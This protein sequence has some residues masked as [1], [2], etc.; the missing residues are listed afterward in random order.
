MENAGFRVVASI[1]NDPHA[2]CTYQTNFSSNKQVLQRDLKTF[3][4]EEL[5]GLI[6]SKT[7]V[8]VIVGG[9][10]CQGFSTARKVDGSNH[11]T[12]II[13]DDRRYLFKYFL[14][15]VEYFRPKIFIMENVRGIKTAGR[16]QIF[17]KI[18]NSGKRIGYQMDEAF[19][20]AWQFGIPQKRIRQVFVGVQNDL[21]AFHIGDWFKPTHADLDRGNRDNL[22]DPVTLWEAIGDLPPLKPGE[23]KTRYNDSKR[24]SQIKRYG[25]RYVT[26][27]LQLDRATELTAHIARMHSD[28]DL[29]DFGKLKE[30]ET[31]AQA[32]ARGVDMEFPYSREIFKDRYTRQHRKRLSSTIVAHLSKDGLMFIHPTQ[33]RSLTPREAARIQSFPDWFEFPVSRTHQYRLIGNAVPPLLGQAIGRAVKRYLRSINKTSL[34][35]AVGD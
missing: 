13:R 3:R 20:R 14:N 30:G 2:I 5:G 31:S 7:V 6:Q 4:P 33:N 9:P 28:R 24:D 11:G 17:T 35:R 1:D 29:R 32:L 23:A 8:D 12:R 22:K 26:D 21:P 34:P 16:N 10:P 15:Y 27:V 25:E 19:V 18:L